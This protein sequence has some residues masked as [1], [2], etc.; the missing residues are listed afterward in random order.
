VAKP[1]LQEDDVKPIYRKRRTS[2]LG[3]EDAVVDD[4]NEEAQFAVPKE[5]VVQEEIGLS[6]K[7]GDDLDLEDEGDP[8]MVSEYVG[9]IFQYLLKLEVSS[10]SLE[11]AYLIVYILARNDAEPSLHGY[12]GGTRMGIAAVFLLTGLSR[13]IN[14]SVSYQRPSSFASTLSIISFQLALSHLSDFSQSV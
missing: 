1:A 7:E 3:S 8:L 9:E 2:S 10:L 6:S 14:V 12:P 4:G 11:D 13:F 5:E